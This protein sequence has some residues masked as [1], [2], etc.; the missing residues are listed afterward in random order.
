MAELYR[1]GGRKSN[2][3][4][5]EPQNVNGRSQELRAGNVRKDTGASASIGYTEIGNSWETQ[6]T[7]PKRLWQAKEGGE[8]TTRG[9]NAHVSQ[10]TQYAGGGSAPVLSS[11]DERKQCEKRSDQVAWRG[12]GGKWSSDR[13]R[14]W[15]FLKS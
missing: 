11:R 1:R 10:A 5:A 7:S 3:S 13:D 14:D 4:S 2:K 12:K 9:G 15:R 8:I 6:E